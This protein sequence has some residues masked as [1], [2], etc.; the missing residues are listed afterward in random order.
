MTFLAENGGSILLCVGLVTLLTFI[1]I[2]L[3]RNR[4]SGCAGCR[5]ACSGCAMRGKCAQ[6]PKKKKTKGVWG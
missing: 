3:V 1:V 5:G 6:P 2:R 4:H